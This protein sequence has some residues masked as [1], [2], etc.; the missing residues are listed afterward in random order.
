MGF[1]AFIG[2]VLIGFWRSTGAVV[3]CRRSALGRQ[4]NW[5]R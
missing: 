3:D 2:C 4:P 5:A 1:Q